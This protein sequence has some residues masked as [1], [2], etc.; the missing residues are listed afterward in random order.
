MD[1]VSCRLDT[2]IDIFTVEAGT[3]SG[4]TVHPPFSGDSSP[5]DAVRA[6][7]SSLAR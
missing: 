4:W 1:K 5:V 6:G 7:I 2:S 3:G